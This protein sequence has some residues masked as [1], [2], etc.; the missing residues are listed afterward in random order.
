MYHKENGLAVTVHVG[1]KHNHRKTTPLSRYIHG[2]N[3]TRRPLS[4]HLVRTRVRCSVRRH[5]VVIAARGE[6]KLKQ[7]ADEITSAGGEAVVVAVDISKVHQHAVLH[8]QHERTVR[9]CGVNCWY[10]FLFFAVIP[11]VLFQYI[12]CSLRRVLYSGNL[13][14]IKHLIGEIGLGTGNRICVSPYDT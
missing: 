4:A 13:G 1:N 12:N 5:Q 7:V 2:G 9:S 3:R 11:V 8:I 6:D 10:T 14:W